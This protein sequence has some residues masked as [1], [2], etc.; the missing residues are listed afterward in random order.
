MNRYIQVEGAFGVIKED[1]GFRK[2]LLRGKKIVRMEFL[3]MSMGYDIN[4]IRAKIQ[5]I[6]CDQLLHEKKIA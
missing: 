5:G 4:R 1:S 2:F 6:R 3:L